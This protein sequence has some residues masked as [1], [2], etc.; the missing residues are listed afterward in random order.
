M[1]MN[2]KFCKIC[3]RRINTTFFIGEKFYEF[4]DGIYCE[5]CAKAIVDK[6]RRR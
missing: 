4:E 1:G 3:K 2:D 5:V 6:R